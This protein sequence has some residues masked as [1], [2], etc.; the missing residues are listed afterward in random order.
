MITRHND[1][2]VTD[3]A[4]FIDWENMHGYIRSKANISA[5]REVAQGYGRLVL[6][7]AYADWRETRF[8]EDSLLLYK[9]GFEP[10]YVPSGFKNNVDVK[11]ATDCID[12]AYKNPNISVFFLVTGD[13]DFIHVVTALR[14]LGKKVIVIA[15]S[16]NASNR[17]GDLVDSLL[18]YDRDVVPPTPTIPINTAKQEIVKPPENLD[19]I[20]KLTVEMLKK[21]AGIPILLTQAKDR[22]IQFY[23][24]FDQRNYGFE[25]FKALM[26]VGAQKGFFVLNTAG[27]RDWV[28]LP[29]ESSQPSKTVLPNSID[30]VY[31][32]IVDIIKTSNLQQTQLS[33]IKFSLIKKFGGFD[34]AVYGYSQFKEL[35]EAGEQLHYFKLVINDKLVNC[36]EAV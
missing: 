21:E 2:A 17:L 31:R 16:N 30:D 9:T 28:T 23:G 33:Y 32:I 6:A 19:E 12:F 25:K 4:M 20:F 10:I 22:F 24:S 35:M 29:Q 7:K 1:L 11:L 18:I 15:Q 14:P 34:E 36:A 13:G 5:L 8:Q 3:V 26:E 27:L